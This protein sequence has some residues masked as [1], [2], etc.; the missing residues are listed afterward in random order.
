[1][2]NKTGKGGPLKLV[3]GLYQL[4]KLEVEKQTKDENDDKVEEQMLISNPV[5]KY[6][7]LTAVYNTVFF[8]ELSHVLRD[9]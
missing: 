6:S 1:M 5:F 7:S 3:I 2:C 8:N 4:V 9:N